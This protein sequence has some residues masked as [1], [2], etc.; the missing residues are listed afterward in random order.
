MTALTKATF[1]DALAAHTGQTK[2]ASA[3]FLDGFIAVVTDSLAKGNDITFT[4][5]GSFK[6]SKRAAR[7]GRNPATGEALKIAASNGATFKAGASLKAALNVK[8]AGKK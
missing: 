6:V 4:G 7:A 8:K 2:T 5:F 1:I 3:E